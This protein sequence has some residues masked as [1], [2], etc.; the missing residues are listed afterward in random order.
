MR[1][2]VCVRADA[3]T[4]SFFLDA[5]AGDVQQA[6][7]SFFDQ[8]SGGNSA[9]SAAAPAADSYTG[10]RTLSG[11][12]APS[13][14]VPG[15]APAGRSAAGKPRK[16]ARR[17]GGIRTLRDVAGEEEEEDKEESNEYYAGGGKSGQAVQGNPR[18]GPPGAD[19]PQDLKA[20]AEELSRKARNGGEKD[21]SEAEGDLL[22][23]TMCFC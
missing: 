16:A 9:A 2:G 7:A 3:A 15:A 19:M 12:P 11:A 20:Y 17:E 14:T 23:C 18:G 21:V 5:A 10:P 1:S 8:G 6:V 4:A 13:S 22:V